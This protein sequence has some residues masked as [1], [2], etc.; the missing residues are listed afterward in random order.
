MNFYK[1]DRLQVDNNV[2]Y[3]KFDNIPR[4][5]LELSDKIYN[6]S[7]NY[8]ISGNSKISKV[9]DIS[10][11]KNSCNNDN[12]CKGINYNNVNSECSLNTT[13]DSTPNI[14]VNSTFC[15]KTETENMESSNIN[16]EELL[17][18]KIY[19]N[20][21]CFSNNLKSYYNDSKNTMIDLDVDLLMSNIKSCSYIKDDKVLNNDMN[22]PEINLIDILKSDL[23]YDEVFKKLGVENTNNK[24]LFDVSSEINN[25]SKPEGDNE[26]INNFNQ[27]IIIIIIIIILTYLIFR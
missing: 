22:E 14:S 1:L 15:I 25:I 10:D 13:I 26:L 21:D 12:T 5:D 18:N 27:L 9:N 23:S 2:N 24:E 7:H 11:C 17:S 6:C 3:E 16:T 19:L 20:L 4:I 8:K